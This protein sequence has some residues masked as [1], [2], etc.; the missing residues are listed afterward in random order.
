MAEKMYLAEDK[1]HEAFHKLDLDHTGKITKENLHQLLGDG[2]DSE[3]LDRIMAEADYHNNGYIDLEEFQ[4]MML[5]G[6]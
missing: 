3:A 1:I 6:E 2:V 5:Q 4:K